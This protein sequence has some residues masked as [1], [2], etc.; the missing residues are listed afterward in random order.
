MAQQDYLDAMRSIF[1]SDQEV[2][3][4]LASMHKP[5]KKTV[6]VLGSRMPIE[7]F[8]AQTKER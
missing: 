8:I 6:K 4:F 7:K 2:Q 1:S 3:E 5:L